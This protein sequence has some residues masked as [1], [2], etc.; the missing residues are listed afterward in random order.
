MVL[1][2]GDKEPAPWELSPRWTRKPHAP[3]SKCSDQVHRHLGTQVHS[4]RKGGK[5]ER[6]GVGHISGL[7]S[8]LKAVKT[9]WQGKGSVRMPGSR[10]GI[11]KS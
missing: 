11:A 2:V 5:L 10:N 9:I 4:A 7:R 1:G 6:K 8:V 3:H